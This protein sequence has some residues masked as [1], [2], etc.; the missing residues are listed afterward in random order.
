M[1]VIGIYD[2]CR[3]LEAILRQHDKAAQYNLYYEETPTLGEILR[4]LT[5]I[6]NRKVFFVP[7][8]APLLLTPLSL[9]R[10]LGIPTPIDVDNLRGY[11]TS[12]TPYHA[13]NLS[14]VLP[15]SLALQDALTESW[16][17]RTAWA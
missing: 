9:L 15:R 13:S 5:I 1:T 16:G 3:A 14:A 7:V 6:L 2:L 4:L 11:I 10:H 8:P 17:S 12:L